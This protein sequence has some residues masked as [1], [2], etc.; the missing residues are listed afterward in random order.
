MKIFE[1][2]SRVDES[3]ETI[4]GAEDTGSHACY[5]IYG[6]MKGREKNRRLR[7]GKGHEEMILAIQGNFRFRGSA[8]GTLNQ[9]QAVHLSGEETLFL[10][11]LTDH[12]AVYVLAG[13]HADA[14]H[15][16]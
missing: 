8:E 9:G 16:G 10:E 15:H 5:L 11:N 3:G 7:P 1:V 13:G 2:I 4:L 14:G 6:R 12:P